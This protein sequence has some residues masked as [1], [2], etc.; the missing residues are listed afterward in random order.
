MALKWAEILES[1]KLSCIFLY[2]IQ[3]PLVY[4]LK[5]KQDP[6]VGTVI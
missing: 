6:A 1:I 5:R 2:Q 4:L 3:G